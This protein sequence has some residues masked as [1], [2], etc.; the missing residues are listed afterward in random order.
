MIL[1]KVHI[2]KN[3]PDPKTVEMMKLGDWKAQA[4]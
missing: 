2:T 4:Y 1:T 3:T